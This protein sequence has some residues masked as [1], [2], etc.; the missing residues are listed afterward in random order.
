MTNV[1]G[2][3][4]PRPPQ[5]ETPLFPSTSQLAGQV[6]A[7]YAHQRYLQ[8]LEYLDAMGP[9]CIF[10]V[11]SGLGCLDHQISGRFGELERV[12]LL[13]RTAQRRTKPAT[14]CNAAVYEL[15]TMGVAHLAAQLRPPVGGGG[16]GAFSIPPSPRP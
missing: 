8:I 11:A 15:T 2:V 10:E 12:Q 4:P 1:V 16:I 7:R 9:S 5:A 3:I 6:A 13:R 14:G